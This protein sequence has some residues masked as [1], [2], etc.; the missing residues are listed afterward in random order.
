MEKSYLRLVVERIPVPVYLAQHY[1]TFYIRERLECGHEIRQFPYGDPLI[2]KRRICP[3]CARAGALPPKKPAQ[4]E[5]DVQV[6]E[7]F[8]RA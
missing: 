6:K 5:R 4:S 3:H 2:A 8:R 1:Q 7:T